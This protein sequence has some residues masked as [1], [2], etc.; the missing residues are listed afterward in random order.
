MPNRRENASI[1]FPQ[2][3][4]AFTAEYNRRR[5]IDERDRHSLQYQL[6]ANYQRMLDAEDAARIEEPRSKLRGMFCRAAVLCIDHKEFC[7]I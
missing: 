5:R 6:K 2:L 3:S 1:G 4:D 7:P